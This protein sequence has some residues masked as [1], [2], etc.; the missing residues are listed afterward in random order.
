MADQVQNSDIK[1]T[2]KCIHIADRGGADY[3]NEWGN[4]DM[5]GRR[6]MGTDLGCILNAKTRVEP[7]SLGIR[8]L[9]FSP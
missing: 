4:P 3:E 1:P 7:A 5:W 8:A 2:E 6:W 9:L